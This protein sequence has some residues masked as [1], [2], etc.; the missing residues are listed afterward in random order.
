[1]RCSLG[2]LWLSDDVDDDDY[3]EKVD[4]DYG[5]QDCVH[6]APILAFTMA[7]RAE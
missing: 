7:T 4:G 2:R 3:N 1:M 5:G 6:W